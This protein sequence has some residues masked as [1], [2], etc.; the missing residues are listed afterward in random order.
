MNQRTKLKKSKKAQKR[1]RSV[2]RF[3]GL[4][5]RLMM[6]FFFVGIVYLLIQTVQI[7][8]AHADEFA[9]IT[10]RQQVYGR[11]GHTDRVIAPNRGS[12]VDRNGQP[13]AVSHTVYNIFMDVRLLAATAEDERST[14]I[15]DTADALHQVFGIEPQRIFDYTAINPETGRPQRDTHFLILERGI[16]PIR[17]AQLMAFGLH[18]VHS[19]EDTLRTYPAGATTAAI[20]GFLSGDGNHWGMERVY[21]HFLTGSAGRLVRM[22][23]EA[24]AV[25]THQFPPTPGYTLVTTIDLGLQNSANALAMEFG[26]RYHAHTAQIIVMNPNTGE[27]YAM[28]QYPSFDNN[29]PFNVS[30]I[31]SARVQAELQEVTDEA[32]TQAL[33]NVWSNRAIA[34][35]FE[36]GSIFKPM[37]HAAALEEGLTYPG[38]SFF[39]PGF[40]MVAGIRINCWHG[41]GHGH[42]TLEQSMAVS[43]NVVSMILGERLGRDLMYEYLRDFGIGQ[44]TG[45]DI[46]GEASVFALTIPRHQLNPVEIAT[47]SFGQGFNMTAIQSMVAFAAVI[48]GG[49]LMVPHVVSQVTNGEEIIYE[50]IPT[51]R[52]NVLSQTTSDLWREA[53]VGTIE[54]YR[55]TARDAHIDGYVVGAKTGTAEVVGPG[56]QRISGAYVRSTLAYLPAYAPRYLV[57]VNLERPTP[58]PGSGPMHRMLRLMLEEVIT[59]RGVRPDG[60]DHVATSPMVVVDDYI[61]S[62]FV[63]AM[64]RLAEKGLL[65]EPIGNGNVII[66]QIPLAGEAVARGTT[67]ILHVASDENVQALVTIPNLVGMPPAQAMEA[68]D[69]LGLS[70]TMLP[71]RPDVDLE[72]ILADTTGTAMVT[73]QQP[74]AG[75][76]LPAE[77]SIMLITDVEQPPAPDEI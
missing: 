37:I 65:A 67:V 46:G 28:A 3:K 35:S 61:G 10:M 76:R 57:L 19:E 45:I 77:S 17:E 36:P 31:N 12:I 1:M 63:D 27:I 72:T 25:V 56:G 53:M 34:H 33:F 47:A 71:G 29:S 54:W 39:C 75:I 23:N 15:A 69:S 9:Q 18:H 60:I 44:T 22:F 7:Y 14:E 38:E 2:R 40:R 4:K 5:L 64:T 70:Y 26:S 52:R 59:Q 49:N 24:G 21:D 20:V 42:L 11:R 68:L 55:G 32:R 6:L 66:G 41:P 16:D 30:F 43:C 73:H 58:D 8:V 48:N 50:N 51:I 62:N 13:M 74:Q